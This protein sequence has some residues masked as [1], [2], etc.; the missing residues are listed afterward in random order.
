MPAPEA[1]LP[2]TIPEPLPS[3]TTLVERQ[4]IQG[5]LD[6]LRKAQLAKD[7]DLF[8]DAYSPTFPNLAEKKK[9]S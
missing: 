1:A 6:Q 3:T 8:F 7:I 2:A 9:R 5:I 4:E